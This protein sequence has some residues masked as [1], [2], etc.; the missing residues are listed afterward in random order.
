MT[1]E[2]ITEPVKSILDGGP[3]ESSKG[4]GKT[5][6]IK[7]AVTEAERDLVKQLADAEGLSVSDYMRSKVL[8]PTTAKPAEIGP[9][10]YGDLDV[11]LNRLEA[12]AAM[13]SNAISSRPLQAEDGHTKSVTQCSM[14]ADAK[15]GNS[16]QGQ[17]QRAPTRK[18]GKSDVHLG[19]AKRASAD[20]VWKR[21]CWI[22]ATAL[23]V[24]YSGG[25]LMYFH[26]I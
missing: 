20:A 12:V 7:A 1:E 3:A 15:S 5:V 17:D 19:L 25:A 14:P 11:R 8:P 24:E 4:G 2:E 23:V 13:V 6:K 10:I 16:V 18:L 9:D 26:M 22:I 21:D